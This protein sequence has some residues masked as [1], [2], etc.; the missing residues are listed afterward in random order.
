MADATIKERS[1]RYTEKQ[2]QKGMVQVKIWVPRRDVD[3]IK[4]EA[5]KLREAH[6]DEDMSFLD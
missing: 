1:K 5:W 4:Q 6:H 3:K 2:L